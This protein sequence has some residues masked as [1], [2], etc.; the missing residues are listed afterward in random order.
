MSLFTPCF[1]R[2]IFFQ[3]LQTTQ[4]SHQLLQTSTGQLIVQ[5]LPTATV[6]GAGAA[7][8]AAAGQQA[9]GQQTIQVGSS[10]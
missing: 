6:A 9:N 2:P 1:I 10:A 4:T 8:A 5:A 3:M 7:G